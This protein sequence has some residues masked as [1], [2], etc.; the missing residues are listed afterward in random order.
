M[1]GG[2]FMCE[3]CKEKDVRITELKENA[4]LLRGAFDVAKELLEEGQQRNKQL[5]AVLSSYTL[6]VKELKRTIHEQDDELKALRA[7]DPT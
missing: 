1:K 2:T 6:T 7:G 5:E 4:D 3:A